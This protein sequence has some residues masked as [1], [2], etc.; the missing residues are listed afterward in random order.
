MRATRNVRA[1]QYIHAAYISRTRCPR[2]HAR[3]YTYDGRITRYVLLLKLPRPFERLT[4]PV[5]VSP[6]RTPRPRLLY[7]DRMSSSCE[8]NLHSSSSSTAAIVIRVP[9]G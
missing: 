2:T 7:R 8:N 6:E 9:P 1:R 3:E 5:G 4:L